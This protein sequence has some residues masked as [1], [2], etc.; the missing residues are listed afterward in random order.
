MIVDRDERREWRRRAAVFVLAALTAALVAGGARSEP[1]LTWERLG[2]MGP[3]IDFPHVKGANPIFARLEGAPRS[4]V[5]ADGSSQLLYFY[6]ATNCHRGEE[7]AN[8][9]WID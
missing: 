6:R 9:A 7:R 4:Y 3:G 8:E 1:S 2:K 5:I